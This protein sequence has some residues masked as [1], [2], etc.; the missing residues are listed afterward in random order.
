MDYA[1]KPSRFTDISV[2]KKIL[3]IHHALLYVFDTCRSKRRFFLLVV[4]G[5]LCLIKFYIKPIKS[6]KSS[7]YKHSKVRPPSKT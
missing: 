2:M 7:K 5:C 1:E 4:N 3:S 6:L